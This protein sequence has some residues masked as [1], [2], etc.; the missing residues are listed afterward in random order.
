MIDELRESALMAA[1]LDLEVL[2][3]E[4]G[5]TR[6]YK[7]VE[8]A[9]NMTDLPPGMRLLKETVGPMADAIKQ[10]VDNGGKGKAGRGRRSAVVAEIAKFDPV[11][12][13]YHTM[14]TLLG[15]AIKQDRVLTAYKALGTDLRNEVVAVSVAINH[16]GYY[17]AM[18]TRIRKQGSA[19]SKKFLLTK[20]MHLEG[21]DV[22]QWDNEITRKVGT[23]LLDMAVTVTGLFEVYNQRRSKTSNALHIRATPELLG[24]LEQ[25]HDVCSEL[26][27]VGLPMVVK[28]LPWTSVTDGGYLTRRRD[29]I[30]SRSEGLKTEYDLHEL[31]PVF[32][33]VNTLQNTGWRVNK[34]VL[35]AMDS[36]WAAGSTLAGLPERD[37]RLLPPKP[38]DIDTNED[39]RRAWS[40][41]AKPIHEFNGKLPA[42]RAK[43]AM[44]LSIA[45]DFKDYD[46]LYFPHQ[47]DFRGRIYPVAAGAVPNPQGSDLHRGLLE[48]SEGKPLGEYGASEL[49]IHGAGLWGIDKCSFD[50]RIQWIEDNSDDIEAAGLDPLENRF[51][52]VAEKP[53]QAL[54]FCMSWAKYQLAGEDAI[55]HMP[56]AVDATCSGLQC[57]SALLLDEIGGK[58]TNL[59]PSEVPSDIYKDVAAVLSAKLV[60]YALTDG[61]NAEWAALWADN[62]DR[63][64]VKTP[65]MTRPYGASLFAM[66]DQ[67]QD[68]FIKLVKKG[69]VLP[70]GVEERNY[71]QHARF[72]SKFL[73][74][75]IGEV[76]VAAESAMGWLQ[77]VATIAAKQGLPLYWTSPVGLPVVQNYKKSTK[78]RVKAHINGQEVQVTVLDE[79]P[80]KLDTQ[81]QRSSIAPNFVHSLD[82]GHLMRTINACNEI[83]GAPLAFA[84]I[85]DS[86]GTHP[87][88]APLLAQTLREQ[89]VLIYSDPI[90][91]RFRDEVI[92]QLP[93]DLKDSLPPVPPMGRLDLEAVT[94]SPY[95]FS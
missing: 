2:S 4:L 64:I 33:A 37:P 85:H 27:P 10:W 49:A 50:D 79:C 32:D 19:Q 23:L 35:A 46:V 86:Y 29:L 78:R 21:V 58:S 30:R 91:E 13:A 84:M 48:F 52:T 17:K 43:V 56:V 77:E 80:D 66:P 68:G 76:V 55:I 7:A 83:N 61:D 40:A 3:T 87:C 73:N 93:E 47:L 38:L 5:V 28:P 41:T 15:S 1:Q 14:R 6:Y 34:R 22:T 36:L 62:I 71:Y 9:D 16:P 57:F 25:S 70:E 54:A 90:L 75:S 94:E 51:W 45:T 8:R 24:W 67:I 95:F 74:E 92:K 26:R 60:A 42:E 81:K 88:D 82:S 44:T 39:A 18:Q 63:D 20:A 72:L 59:V 69:K 53:V 65:V 12:L 89:F 11:V 31:G